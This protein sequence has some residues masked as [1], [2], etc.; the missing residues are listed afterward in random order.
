MAKAPAS[1]HVRAAAASRQTG[2]NGDDLAYAVLASPRGWE[3]TAA[4]GEHLAAWTADKMAEPGVC[5]VTDCGSVFSAGSASRMV[6]TSAK[7]R[8]AGLWWDISGF[9][10]DFIKVKAHLTRQE[11]IARGQGP[12][13]GRQ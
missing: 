9:M 8:W 6:A 12:P 2:A 4:A 3:Q 10:G 1:P 11:A 7:R 5:Y 13:L